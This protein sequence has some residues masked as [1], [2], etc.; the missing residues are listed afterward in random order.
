MCIHTFSMSSSQRPP[1]THLK[2]NNLDL[3][4]LEM[5]ANVHIKKNRGVSLREY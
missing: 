2:L 3:L 5:K 4:L 1:E